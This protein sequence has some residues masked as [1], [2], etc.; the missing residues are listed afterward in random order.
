VPTLPAE[1]R[2]GDYRDFASD[3]EFISSGEAQVEDYVRLLELLP[4][5]YPVKDVDLTEDEQKRWYRSVRAV[6]NW[7]CE[8]IQTGLVSRGDEAPPPPS[9]LRVLAFEGESPRYIRVDDPALVY[10]DNNFLAERWM[11]QCIFLLINDDWRRLRNWL[12]VPNLSEVVQAQWN[13]EGKLDNETQQLQKRFEETLPFYLALIKK[14]QPANYQRILSRFERLGVQVVRHLSVEERLDRLPEAKP[15]TNSERLHL[16]KTDEPNPRGGPPVRGGHLFVTKEVL[17]NLD[18]LGEYIADYVEIARLGDAFVLLVNRET[19]RGKWQFL[20]SKGVT[21]EDLEEIFDDLNIERRE[22]QGA[23]QAQSTLNFI[24]G[25]VIDEVKTSVIIPTSA[26]PVATPTV[27]SSTLPEDKGGGQ[28]VTVI[29]TVK[30]S[31]PELFF[32]DVPE[33][34]F[35]DVDSVPDLPIR[36]KKIGS[37]RGGGGGGIPPA[38]ITQELGRRGEQWAYE[39]E[40]RRLEEQGF[41]PA[42]LEEMEELV[43]V[44]KSKPTANY[45]I[46]SV[47]E[48]ETGEQRTVY[49]E[50]KASS[51]TSREI[52]MSRSEFELALSLGKDYWLYWVANVET[53]EPDPPICFPNLA[54]LIA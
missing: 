23:A 2:S 3:L 12:G 42:E 29:P 38:E 8:R 46:K 20:D 32:D 17:S 51:G 44:A 25:K 13:W 47:R 18:L 11:S 10:P 27:D 33:I 9:N 37:R 52:K 26:A 41:D 15:V 36:K 35:W 5:R 28:E 49:I 22:R 19:E 39:V 24:V 53:A 54:H 14:A 48:T 50:V 6:F 34:T 21:K 31:Y 45:D 43:W 16:E 7:I 1:L 40:K 4:E 30:P